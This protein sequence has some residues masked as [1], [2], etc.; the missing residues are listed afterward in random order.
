MT[1]GQDII[2][3]KTN[4]LDYR[5]GHVGALLKPKGHYRPL[6]E[7]MNDPTIRTYHPNA[8]LKIVENYADKEFPRSGEL[9]SVVSPSGISM[10]D[11]SIMTSDGRDARTG[12]AFAKGSH[13]VPLNRLQEVKRINK[14]PKSAGIFRK[15][16]YGTFIEEPTDSHVR[17]SVVPNENPSI[18]QMQFP[19][20]NVPR[21]SVRYDPRNPLATTFDPNLQPSN[22]NPIVVQETVQP[23]T[24]APRKSNYYEFFQI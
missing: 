6:P 17:V 15:I 24:P 2:L 22:G 5:P 10:M 14:N 1:S 20:P 4:L 7:D 8:N 18:T 21:A 13:I 23:G 12:K 11:A 16:G 9:V 19:Q 3:E